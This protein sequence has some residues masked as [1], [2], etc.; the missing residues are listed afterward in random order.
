[1]ACVQPAISWDAQVLL[2]RARESISNLCCCQE[3]FLFRCRTWYLSLLDLQ[4]AHFSGLSWSLWMVTLLF[5]T[6]ECIPLLPLVWSYL[7]A[8]WTRFQV[9]I[10]NLIRT[11]MSQSIL[12][13]GEEVLWY[14]HMW[15]GIKKQW[16]KWSCSFSLVAPGLQIFRQK[17]SPTLTRT[18]LDFSICVLQ[19]KAP[20]NPWPGLVHQCSSASSETMVQK[21]NLLHRSQNRNLWYG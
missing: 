12:L 2:S 7:Q 20:L 21:N 3:F 14:L 11:G 16:F 1:M 4:Q 13:E 19:T 6:V 15:W 8:L 9:I 18:C 5:S 10:K 17:I